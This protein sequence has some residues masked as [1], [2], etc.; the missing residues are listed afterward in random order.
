[1]EDVDPPEVPRGAVHEAFR[2]LAACQVGGDGEDLPARLATD[3]LGRRLEHVL[4]PRADRDV[5]ALAREHASDAFADPETAAGLER[6]FAAELQIHGPPQPCVSIRR[7]CTTHPSRPLAAS[8]SWARPY[9]AARICGS[10]PDAVATWQTS[11]CPDS[12]T[13]SSCAATWP[14]RR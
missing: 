7:D 8:P 5:R 1:H 12:V 13:R 2:V 4:A 3:L 14:T 10:S 11:R 6:H 9:A